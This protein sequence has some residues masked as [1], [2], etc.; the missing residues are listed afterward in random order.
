MGFYAAGSTPPYQA[1]QQGGGG[2]SQKLQGWFA[3]LANRGAAPASIAV[4]GDSVTCG[5][6]ASSFALSYPQLL[7]AQLRT[8][9]T[10]SATGGRGFLPPIIPPSNPTSFA[11]AYVALTGPGAASL[12]NAGLFGFGPNLETWDISANGATTVTYTLTGDAA[13]ILWAG[14]PGNGTIGWAVTGGGSGT[15]VTNVAFT[16]GGKTRISLG[17]AGAH[18]L[19]ITNSA[20]GPTYFTGIIEY[21]GDS[22]SGVQVHG[23]GYSGSSTAF[24]TPLA[25]LG[26]AVAALSPGL[27]VLELGLNDNAAAITPAA[28]GSNLAAVIAEVRAALTAPAAPFLLLEAYNAA[29][30]GP[31]SAGLWAQYVNAAYSV[32]ASDAFTD[33][34]DLTYYRMPST[35]AAVTWGLYNVDGIHPANP[36]HQMIADTMTRYLLPG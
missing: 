2:H 7:A 8:R 10:G 23:C 1:Y 13:D 19:T 22:A 9:M 15:I 14:S 35:A 16:T 34:L 29:S 36:G 3:A 26:Q 12:H 30:D 28:Y 31:T 5:Q 33:V 11:P 6:G 21:N 20:G 27:V 18:T 17:T 25:S 32:A 24:W 4:L